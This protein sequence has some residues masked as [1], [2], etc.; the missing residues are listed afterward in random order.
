M[1]HIPNHRR[2]K[3]AEWETPQKGIACGM[4]FHQGIKRLK[5][6][7]ATPGKIEK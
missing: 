2:L 7:R 3:H 6:L 4:I 5:H 1:Q